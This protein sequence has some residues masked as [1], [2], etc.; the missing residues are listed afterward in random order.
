MQDAA[1]RNRTRVRV[2]G[3]GFSVQSSGK[4]CKTQQDV[5]ALMRRLE[6]VRELE[7]NPAELVLP[8]C[9]HMCGYMRCVHIHP[10]KLALP[11]SMYTFICTCVYI[12]P[13][14]LVLCLLH[15]STR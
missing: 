11:A 7:P 4:R 3:L 8:V 10:A 9:I 13:A 5:N 1:G 6:V 12:H 2:S 14:E 15:A